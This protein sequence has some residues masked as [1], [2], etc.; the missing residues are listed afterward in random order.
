MPSQF[1]QFNPLKYSYSLPLL[2][3]SFWLDKAQCHVPNDIFVSLYE[4]NITILPQYISI[5]TSFIHFKVFT[6]YTSFLPQIPT[7][8]SIHRKTLLP[9]TI[10]FRNYYQTNSSWNECK[11]IRCTYPKLQLDT[12]ISVNFFSD[13]RSLNYLL[14]VNFYVTNHNTNYN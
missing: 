4:H 3:W 10:M 12:R 14:N 7:S 2:I 11:I 5:L 13:R 9:S 1:Y 8:T 6:V